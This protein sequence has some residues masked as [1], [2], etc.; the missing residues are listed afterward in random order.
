VSGEDAQVVGAASEDGVAG[1]AGARAGR[2]P[3][4][5]EWGRSWRAAS[6]A[7][8]ASICAA[9]ARRSL[10]GSLNALA[11]TLSARA[12]STRAMSLPC[13]CIAWIAS[14]HQSRIGLSDGAVP[15][16]RPAC[17]TS[18]RA[19]GNSGNASIRASRSLSSRCSIC[20]LVSL[21]I[22]ASRRSV[23][24]SP[25]GSMYHRGVW[26][27][28]S[29]RRAKVAKREDHEGRGATL[30]RASP[31]PATLCG[32]GCFALFVSLRALAVREP[33]TLYSGS[34]TSLRR[35]FVMSG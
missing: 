5:V 10:I 33:L 17:R 20:A 35:R 34:A 30:S 3:R 8:C 2:R 21:A 22:R 27:T 6:V 7:V 28:N 26:T 23:S 29:R 19:S 25:R 31:A 16:A 32:Q 13:R 11:I 1:E 24:G 15:G 18:A 14:H 12:A 4:R 9:S